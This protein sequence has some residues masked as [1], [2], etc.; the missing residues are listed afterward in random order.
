M[1]ILF[2]SDGWEIYR[3]PLKQA[4]DEFGINFKE[5]TTNQNLNKADIEF[6]IY[7][8]KS[9]L[10]DFSGFS[11]LKAVLN[12]WAGVDE[13]VSNSTLECTL[14]R[15][16]DDGLTQGMNEWC[17]AHVLRHHLS[18]DHHI[19]HQ[20]GLWRS[21]FCPP[22]ASE[23]CV[24][25]LGLGELG[26]TVAKSLAQVGFKVVG[27]S[28]TEKMLT[29]VRSYTGM[30]GL[31]R[32]L[33]KSELLILLLPLTPATKFIINAYTLALLPKGAIIINPGRGLL[34]N[35]YD[36]LNALN[37]E[38]LSHA[39]L[40]VFDTEPLPTK[41]PYWLHPKVTVTP[42]IAAATRPKFSSKSIA[43]NIVRI[44]NGRKPKGLVEVAKLY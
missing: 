1:T 17:M 4:F 7:S 28:Q 32:V 15:M 16:I 18:I 3:E 39:T 42:H 38:Q 31:E 26:S 12:L 2:A 33:K 30:P 29:D 25:V 35:D 23:R 22:L 5:V 44:R 13:I 41:H 24:G 27:W 9:G 34:V 19:K 8:P 6:I 14:V 20:D 40:D 10:S 36:L 11:N 21:D 37:N 43:K